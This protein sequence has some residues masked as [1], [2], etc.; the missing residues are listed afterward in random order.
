M[1]DYLHSSQFCLSLAEDHPTSVYLTGLLTDG[2][3]LT[4]SELNGMAVHKLSK[5]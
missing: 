1:E 3:P 5:L 4:V 2:P